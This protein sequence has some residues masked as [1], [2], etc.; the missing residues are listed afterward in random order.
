[1]CSG[2]GDLYDPSLRRDARP[3]QAGDVRPATHRRSSATRRVSSTGMRT[4]SLPL[5]RMT[6]LAALI[7]AQADA[8][9][10]A[11]LLHPRL[12]GDS[13]PDHPW[14]ILSLAL[15]VTVDPAAGSVA[16]TA[17][18]T[19]A[20]YAEGVQPFVLDGVAL[21]IVAVTVDGAAF[22]WRTEPDRIVLDLAGGVNHEIAV[23]YHATPRTGLH[24]RRP[25]RDATDTYPEVWSQGEGED[26][27]FWFPSY[28]H[29]NDR[30]QYTGTVHAPDGLKTYTNS[31][32]DLVNYLVMLVAAPYATFGDDTNSVWAPPGTP[33]EALVPILDPIPRMRAWFGTRTGVAYP[34]GTYRQVFVQRFMYGGM[35]NTSATIESTRLL[36]G[37]LNQPTRPGTESVVAHELAHQWYGDLLTSR[38]W[39][40]LWLNEGFATFMAADWM[41]NGRTGG[42]AYAWAENVRGWYAASQTPGSLTGAWF[43]GKDT[44]ENQAVYVKGASVLTMLQAHL[45]DAVFWRAIADY[46]R[47]HQHTLVVT[48]DLQRAMETAS[49]QNLD[50]FF[51]QWTELPYVPQL[52]T[53]W[54]WSAP[55]EL[56]VV[57]HQTEDATHPLY[58][59]PIAVEIG[60]EAAPRRETVWMDQD[61]LTVHLTA[62]SAPAW[63]A[64][65]PNGGILAVRTDHQ[66]V[67]QWSAQ[68][69]RSP[70][71]YA[72]LG[73]IEALG[74]V[75]GGDATAA[76]SA[77]T[78][79]L[80]TTGEHEEIRRA[81]AT[82]LGEQRAAD[83]LLVALADPTVASPP[84]LRLAV[85]NALVKAARPGDADT[86]AR[87]R[88]DETNGDIRAALLRALAAAD[89]DRALRVSRPLLRA[90][91]AI[92]GFDAGVQDSE[93]R[94][95]LD[96][97]GEHGSV[98][99]LPLLLAAP[100]GHDRRAGGLN[101]ATRVVS[102]MDLGT[103]REAAR[104]SVARS[105]ESLLGDLDLRTRSAAIGVLAEVG[106]TDTITQLERFRREE[107][108]P[109]VVE[110]AG[111]TIEAIRARHDAVTPPTP[112]EVDA[113]LKAF[114]DRLKSLED[115]ERGWQAH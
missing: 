95:A 80:N 40:H 9:E 75:T 3:D 45:G 69:Q 105:A 23:Q 34:W 67:A 77:L 29:P 92:P 101:A 93:S 71:A 16:G 25:G 56:D 46:T 62:P 24:F 41:A 114:E 99:D 110:A 22:P 19:V 38:D 72:R 61:T 52:E 89:V 53:S 96:V 37:P 74:A 44:P 103:T 51:E 33:R 10:P 54:T 49:G 83:A 68:A 115:R 21:D 63:V 8:D 11:P 58:T 88:G 48:H 91:P 106:D 113:R 4:S 86:L 26:N 81:A 94:A 82:A 108:V 70:S 65:D 57:I 18:Y 76:Q 27:R 30:F 28:D 31:G 102:R 60:N 90:S 66:T 32:V 98:G 15:D 84:L 87:A 36:T 100:V 109:A 111:R 97:I 13:V 7:P 85:A 17:T 43:L 50:W 112:N 1:M 2:T 5:A 104:R 73:A 12:R 35:E 6:L 107:E 78:T 39:H 14:D 20:P 59:L 42:D 55:D 79:L 64:V 47:T